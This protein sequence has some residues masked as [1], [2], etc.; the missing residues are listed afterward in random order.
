VGTQG[1]NTIN[2]I[3]IA[4]STPTDQAADNK[5]KGMMEDESSKDVL[6]KNANLEKKLEID[7]NL[8]LK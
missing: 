5:K 6:A 3:S 2:I 1:Q 7:T 8:N 4:T